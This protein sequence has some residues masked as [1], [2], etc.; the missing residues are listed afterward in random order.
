VKLTVEMYGLA[1]YTELNKVDLEIGEGAGIG[2]LV[3][4][5]GKKLPAF[6]GQVKE[7]GNNRLIE[8]YGIYLNSQF[9]SQDDQV[10]L[11]PGDRVVIILQA[12]GG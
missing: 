4:A 10:T 5:L 2:D 12:V 6:E 11:K 8:K 9:I 7:K 3:G 1:P